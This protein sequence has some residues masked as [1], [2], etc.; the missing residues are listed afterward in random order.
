MTSSP[1]ESAREDSAGTPWA[2]RHFEQNSFAK[3]DGS[4]APALIEAIRRVRLGSVGPDEVI[5]QLHDTRVLIPLVTRLGESG[6]TESGRVVDKSQELSVVSVMAPDGRAALPI[7]SSAATLVE[8]NPEARPVPA[9]GARVALAAAGEQTPLLILDPGS[10]TEFIVRSEALEYIAM[11][12][13]WTPP[14][15]DQ[16]VISAF[17]EPTN[18]FVEIRATSLSNGDPTGTMQAAE[19]LVEVSLIPGLDAAEVKV[20]SDELQRRW[21]ADPVIASRVDSVR[22]RFKLYQDPNTL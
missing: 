16:R 11:G 7:F 21:A 14:W 8:W 6:T 9:E 4:A 3:D 5:N 17:L 12:K 2:G 22:L 20:V 10:D 13:H 15:M 18:E 19:L 1:H